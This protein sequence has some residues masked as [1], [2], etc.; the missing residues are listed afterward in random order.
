MSDELHRQI[1]QTVKS[2]RIVL[3]MKG[4]RAFP[5]CG[6]SA[7]VVDL[8]EQHETEF[9]DVDVLANPEL[10]VGLKEYANWPTF[11]Q[12]F[13]DGKLVGGCDIVTELESSGELKPLLSPAQ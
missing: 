7:K 13:V 8:L 12:L 1:D 6:F 2:N 9:L 3:F 4:N 11:P 10:K 5:R